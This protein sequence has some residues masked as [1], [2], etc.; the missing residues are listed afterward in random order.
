MP[1]AARS[2]AGVSAIHQSLDTLRLYSHPDCLLHAN[3]SGHP[4]S[5]ARL[6][7]VLEALRAAGLRGIEWVEAPC[8]TRAQLAQ[9]HTPAHIARVLDTTPAM[10]R[11]LVSDALAT[12]RLTLPEESR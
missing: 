5:P 8:A 2:T 10:S 1:V 6:A 11:R 12:L 9:V 7:G 3:A 4:E